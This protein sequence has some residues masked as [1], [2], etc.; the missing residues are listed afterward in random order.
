MKCNA[1]L[2]ELSAYA[3]GELSP[4]EMSAIEAHLGVCDRCRKELASLCGVSQAFRLAGDLEP[5][6]SVRRSVARR[7]AMTE[8][9]PEFTCAR[10]QMSISAMLDGELSEEDALILQAHLSTC[11]ACASEV[12]SLEWVSDSVRALPEV[13][14]PFG[15]ERRIRT[16]IAREE[17]GV[18]SLGWMRRLFQPRMAPGMATALA[19][20]T[21]VVGFWLGRLYPQAPGTAPVAVAPPA[22]PQVATRMVAPN[23]TIR[24][25][26]QPAP[27]R[28]KPQRRPAAPVQRAPEPRRVA[29]R[30][31][32][33]PKPALARHEEARP[34]PAHQSAHRPESAPSPTAV[35]TTSPLPIV[36]PLPEAPPPVVELPTPPAPAPEAVPA[37]PRV[38]A[39]ETPPPT[40]AEPLPTI[41]MPE[42]L[43]ARS[44]RHPEWWQRA[45]DVEQ[46]TAALN[47]DPPRKAVVARIIK[48][49]F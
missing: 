46:A 8:E 17:Q 37:P 9:A 1:S 36:R 35:A 3:D 49:S 21:L 34:A 39:R 14:L 18:F 29:V 33:A 5:G 43:R 32:P 44:V 22:K 42:P 15:L 10:M 13:E 11:S 27:L 7:L 19:G 41:H 45:Q 6:L 20:A 24:V 16:A 40:E 4:A 47:G 30:T 2:E 25:T 31:V 23:T 28:A 26:E 38:A 12:A 48:A